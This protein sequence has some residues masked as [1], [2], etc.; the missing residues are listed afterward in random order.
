MAK[1]VKG[2]GIVRQRIMRDPEISRGAKTVYAYLCS[3]CGATN[4]CYPPQQLMCYELGICRNTL[5]KYFDELTEKKIVEK[6][7]KTRGKFS[8]YTYKITA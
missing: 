6:V 8:N 5:V 2:Y 4:T 3:Y 7:R 1:N